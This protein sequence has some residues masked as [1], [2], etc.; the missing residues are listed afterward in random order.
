MVFGPATVAVY[1]AEPEGGGSRQREWHADT[2]ARIHV[3]GTRIRSA[4]DW[5]QINED[6]AHRLAGEL[7]NIHQRVRPINHALDRL[8]RHIDRDMQEGHS[9]LPSAA[10]AA[11]SGSNRPR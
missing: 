1:D 4:A 7:P 6:A 5:G 8:N 10:T 9:S 11:P 3:T 2:T